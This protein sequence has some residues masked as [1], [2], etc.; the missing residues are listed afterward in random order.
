[1]TL[2]TTGTLGTSSGALFGIEAA[3]L[4]DL[5]VHW[6]IEYQ[7]KRKLFGLIFEIVVG[8]LLGVFVNGIGKPAFHRPRAARSGRQPQAVTLT[9]GAPPLPADNFAH[10]GG[11]AVGLLCAIL[12]LP[13][14]H[15][16]RRHKLVVWGLRAVA[17]P[18]LLVLFVV[19]AKNFYTADPSASC[20]WCRYL[21][22]FPT[23][24]NDRCSGTGLSSVSTSVVLGPVVA[25]LL[26]RVFT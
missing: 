25:V 15:P 9:P 5:I 16:S 3:L 7:P 14:V 13:I 6:S 17:L 24:S 26:A 19:L 4:V 23:S 10:I 22:C 11:W 2:L 8:M 20:S 18:V 12:F 21:S 1:M